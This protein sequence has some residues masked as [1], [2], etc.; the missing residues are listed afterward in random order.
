MKKVLVFLGMICLLVFSLSCGGGG[1]APEGDMEEATEAAEDAAEA[2]DE[3]GEESQSPAD[4]AEEL[5]DDAVD[6][7]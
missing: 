4:Q 6:A 3:A 7:D 2:M 5:D 1:E